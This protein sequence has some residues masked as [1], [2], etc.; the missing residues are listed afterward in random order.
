MFFSYVEIDYMTFC[1]LQRW[2]VGVTSTKIVC[3]SFLLIPYCRMHLS[4]NWNNTMH[5]LS[6]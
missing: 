6:F 5:V 1:I 3:T 4:A 2:A